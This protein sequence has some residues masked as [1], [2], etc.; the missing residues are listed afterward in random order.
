[1]FKESA[2]I[3]DKKRVP[4]WLALTALTAIVAVAGLTIANASESD[5]VTRAA[6]PDG[7]IKHIIVI[8]MEN[9]NFADT[10][11]P[12][13]PATYLNSTLLKEGQLV[14]NYYGTS[15]A[16]LGNYL[17]QVSGQAPTP[18]INNDCVD[19]S[20]FAPPFNNLRGGFTNVIPGTDAADSIKFPGQVVGDGCVFPAPTAHLHGAQTIADQ[21]DSVKQSDPATHVAS[22]RMY[23]EDMGND[24]ARDYGTPDPKGGTSCAHP[25]IGGVDNSNNASVIDQYATRHNPFVYFHSI[26]D[27]QP[28]CDANVVPLGKVIVGGHG[29]PDV[30]TGHLAEDLSQEETTPAFAFITPNLCNDGHDATCTGINTEGT[31][32]GGLVGI[33]LW[34][35]HWMPLILNSPAYRK[36]NTLVVLTFDEANPAGPNG[37][38]RACC[39]EQPGPNISNP[40][41]TPILALLGFQTTPTHGA[42]LYPG[43]GQVGAVLFNSRYIVPGSTNT[44]GY[45]NHYSALRSYED[46]L[47]FKDGDD[48]Y[49]HL[50]FAAAPGLQPFGKDVF[51]ALDDQDH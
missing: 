5:P 37:D 13:S 1:M 17:A 23:A 6:L 2:M 22:W 33:D 35:K 18:S 3:V 42:V 48:G 30:F 7:A 10:F 34:L 11:G 46:L 25:P 24:P 14:H 44:V 49:G 47:G 29:K 12:L 8:D 41:F 36:G 16:S 39:F 32:A 4:D 45:Y 21:L 20:T 15:H 31:T 40:G 38:S 27:R 26:I 9:E 43:G 19:L 28:V 50:G 51:N